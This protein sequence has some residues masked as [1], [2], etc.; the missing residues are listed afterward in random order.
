MDYRYLDAQ[1][2]MHS[3]VETV[4]SNVI[5]GGLAWLPLSVRVGVYKEAFPVAVV[6]SLLVPFSLITLSSSITIPL[7]RSSAFRSL[8]STG[9]LNHIIQRQWLLPRL[10][11]IL[12][13]SKVM[14][15]LSVSGAFLLAL[16]VSVS[17]VVGR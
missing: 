11:L 12:T 15:L 17:I 13:R 4:A 6:V 5:A 1:D 9:L 16:G 3:L 14:V 7:T 10:R 2:W 8:F